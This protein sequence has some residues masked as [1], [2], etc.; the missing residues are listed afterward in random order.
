MAV[1]FVF[2]IWS[3]LIHSGK[4]TLRCIPLVCGQCLLRAF[5]G[6]LA[7]LS[8]RSMTPQLTPEQR[9]AV[10]EHAGSPVYLEDGSTHDTYVLLPAD[11]FRRLRPLFEPDEVRIRETYPA[12]EQVAHTE[13]WDDP[14]MDEYDRYDAHRTSP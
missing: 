13:G 5:C 14:A 9:Q 4:R 7:S 2:G 12:Q 1:S 11:M 10:Q 8:R 6:I 3:S